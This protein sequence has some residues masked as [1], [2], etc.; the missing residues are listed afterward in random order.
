MQTHEQRGP[1][2][3][4]DR[5]LTAMGKILLLCWFGELQSCAFSWCA[6]GNRDFPDEKPLLGPAEQSLYRTIVGKLMFHRR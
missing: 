2:G 4:L 5:T 1:D 3:A 6:I